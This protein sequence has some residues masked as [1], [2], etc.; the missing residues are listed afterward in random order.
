MSWETWTV[1]CSSYHS[2]HPSDPW[3]YA[4]DTRRFCTYIRLDVRK[5]FFSERVVRQWHRLHRE[6]AESPSLQVFK[7]HADVVLRDMG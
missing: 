2:A 6:V 5:N 4:G 3:K 1:A 7:N